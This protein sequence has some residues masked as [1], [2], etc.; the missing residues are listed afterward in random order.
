[1]SSAAATMAGSPAPA[2]SPSAFVASYSIR[3]GAFKGEVDMEL[4][5]QDSA[6]EYLFRIESRARG[7]A[8]LVQ[9]GTATEE[10]RFLIED[11]AITPLE[12]HLDGGRK[13][14]HDNSDVVFDWQEL[15]AY[16]TY[17]DEA[18][19]LQLTPDV[20]DRLS[21]DIFLMMQLAAGSPPAEFKIAEKNAVR[22]YEFNRLG[23]ETIATPAGEFQTVKYL[24]HRVG[25]SR[26]TRIWYAIDK[27]YLPVRIEQLK[28][29]EISIVSV[30][31][32]IHIG[33]L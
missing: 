12:Y 32:S 14:A 6:G 31:E 5:L 2:D 19:T 18:T 16:S 29:G 1:M 33:E 15:V 27:N 11:G 28:R 3:F 4:S 20:R 25:S 17:E 30:A 13:S 7:L 9:P 21:T 8:R 23:E 10:S 26:S 24:R 22:N